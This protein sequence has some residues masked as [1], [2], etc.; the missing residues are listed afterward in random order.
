MMKIVNEALRATGTEGGAAEGPARAS[1]ITGLGAGAAESLAPSRSRE[2]RVRAMFEADYDF[3]WRSLR[4][5][6]VPPSRVDDAAQQVFVVASQKLDAIAEGSERSFLFGTAMRVASD[7]RRSAPVRREIAS[8]GADLEVDQAP[9]P[10]ELVERRR[11]RALL[12][13]VLDEMEDDLRAVLVMFELEGLSSPE[14]A[15]L[16]NIPVGTVASRLRRAREDFEAR[17]ARIAARTRR[18]P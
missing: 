7:V 18:T 12:D 10:D 3:I 11:A 9:L 1:R 4:R 6:G 8:D 5:F 16:M 14:I 2:A 13:K 17:V 15:E